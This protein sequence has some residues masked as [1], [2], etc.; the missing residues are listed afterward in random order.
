MNIL[1]ALNCR[2]IQDHTTQ[3][4]RLLEQKLLKRLLSL[5]SSN[6]FLPSVKWYKVKWYLSATQVVT[7]KGGK[8]LSQYIL[9]EKQVLRLYYH[10][11]HRVL[12]YPH[13]GMEGRPQRTIWDLKFERYDYGGREA[14]TKHLL[15][16]RFS[17]R[18]FLHHTDL[19]SAYYARAL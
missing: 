1:D 12:V 3:E 17:I 15:E 4:G 5:S 14:P 9:M 7:T 8:D 11:S 19:W 13:P 16:V 10:V 2:K 6:Y 18:C